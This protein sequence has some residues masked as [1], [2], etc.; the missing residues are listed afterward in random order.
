MQNRATQAKYVYVDKLQLD[1]LTRSIYYGPP[2]RAALRTGFLLGLA[3]VMLQ[4]SPIVHIKTYTPNYRHKKRPPI[5]RGP[6]IKVYFLT[7]IL[8]PSRSSTS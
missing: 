3:V 7:L 6:L 5:S 1:G 8:S 2:R 4:R